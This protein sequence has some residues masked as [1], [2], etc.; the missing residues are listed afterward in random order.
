[1]LNFKHAPPFRY[2]LF[3]RCLQ[4]SN[5]W[6]SPSH[7]SSSKQKIQTRR[8]PPKILTPS[9]FVDGSRRNEWWIFH[10]RG[11][12]RRSVWRS[13]DQHHHYRPEADNGGTETW[14]FT[15]GG[16]TPASDHLQLFTIKHPSLDPSPDAP[17]SHLIRSN[18][19]R[20]DKLDLTFCRFV[21][22]LTHWYLGTFPS[23]ST[24][25]FSFKPWVCWERL[26]QWH[27]RDAAVISFRGA[28]GKPNVRDSARRER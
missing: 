1:M 9:K 21:L 25:H 3:H 26:E 6:V 17:S 2:R 28:R 12:K 23:S 10:L 16:P 5:K 15:R 13:S 19:A 22:I 11:L 4:S 24:H 27:C 14:S 8:T 18:D 7:A 20:K